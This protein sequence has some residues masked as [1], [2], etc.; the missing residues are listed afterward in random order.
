MDLLQKQVRI[1]S[2]HFV[3]L[4]LFYAYAPF[5]YPPGKNRKLCM[6]KQKPKPAMI[7]INNNIKEKNIARRET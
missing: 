7:R 3:F 2:F 5:L 1:R 4:K 6:D